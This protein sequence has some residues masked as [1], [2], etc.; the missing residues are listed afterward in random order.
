MQNH[1]SCA[2]NTPK[3]HK[4]HNY[5][6]KTTTHM[7]RIPQLY[8]LH[9]HAKLQHVCKE[10]P[11]A[12]QQQQCGGNYRCSSCLSLMT[13]Q[14][15]AK[16][17][18]PS[19]LRPRSQGAA[20]FKATSMAHSP[21]DWPT[22]FLARSWGCQP[23]RARTSPGTPP[24]RPMHTLWP[25]SA[26]PSPVLP[27]GA[28]HPC[29][30]SSVSLLSTKGSA[31]LGYLWAPATAQA[32]RRPARRPLR[33]CS[34]TST[35]SPPKSPWPLGLA[36]SHADGLCGCPDPVWARRACSVL[37]SC[38]FTIRGPLLCLQHPLTPSFY[39]KYNIFSISPTL[40]FLLFFL[41][42]NMM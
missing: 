34:R 36:Q 14:N 27:K 33:A 3:L 16:N 8:K 22:S 17:K 4:L 11:T 29:P 15:L 28:P 35:A 6:C 32:A 1:S 24:R 38:F 30:I 37:H 31:S 5:M 13:S 19:L 41:T 20:G 18:S 21:D 26:G 40:K 10:H 2:K 12:V 9:T 42:S 7:Q 25:H 23:G 39:F